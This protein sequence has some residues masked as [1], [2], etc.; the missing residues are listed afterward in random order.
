MTEQK[1][2]ILKW[3]RYESNA[4]VEDKIRTLPLWQG[5]SWL[6]FVFATLNGIPSA[7]L[8][9]ILPP[10]YT[11]TLDSLA[12]FCLVLGLISLPGVLRSILPWK[13]PRS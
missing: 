3:L 7:I 10:M 13:S 4:W 8:S 5:I 12:V 6:G 2:S 11:D 1:P 9:L